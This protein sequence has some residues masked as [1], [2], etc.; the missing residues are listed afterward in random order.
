MIMLDAYYRT[1]KG[2]EVLIEKEWISFGHQFLQRLGHGDDRHSDTDRSPIFQQFI[3]CVWQIMQQFPNVFEFNENF[4]ITLMDYSYNCLFGTFICNSEQQR[5]KENIK[6]K[7]IS[8]WSM[9]NS[10][11]EAYLNPLYS[12]QTKSHVIFP[13]AS[14]RRLEFWT[15]YYCRWNPNLKPQ[16]SIEHRNK[17]LLFAKQ[18]LKMH[19]AALQ[20]EVNHNNN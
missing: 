13:I 6:N 1:L 20:R 16:V 11:P 17:E 18:K 9:I 15:S 4:L 10:S 7:T 8:F 3:D 19:K 14:P 12:E 5:T 2:F